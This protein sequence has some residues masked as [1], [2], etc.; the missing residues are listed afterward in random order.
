M[1]VY[2]FGQNSF[3]FFDSLSLSCFDIYILFYFVIGSI[4]IFFSS[5]S[6]PN[7]GGNSVSFNEMFL[8]LEFYIDEFY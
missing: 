6:L 4:C 5:E 3:T 8:G 2:R 1:R 7:N